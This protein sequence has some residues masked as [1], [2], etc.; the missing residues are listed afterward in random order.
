[1]DLDSSDTVF[2]F[3]FENSG[4]ILGI[5][6]REANII[7]IN[8]KWSN[9]LGYRK[10]EINGLNYYK[11]VHSD[12]V[13]DTEKAIELIVKKNKSNNITNRFKLKEGTYFLINW[14]IIPH[15]RYFILSGHII[16]SQNQE[17][18][19]LKKFKYSTDNAMDGVVWI[20]RQAGFDYVNR[21]VCESLGYTKEELLKLTVFDI[22]PIFKREDFDREWEDYLNNREERSFHLET[23]HKRKDGSVFPVEISSKHYWLGVTELHVAHIRDITKR[24]ENELFLNNFKASIES[25]VD[26]VYWINQEGRFEYFNTGACKMLGY[27]QEELQKLS[28]ADLDPKF[29]IEEH[30]STLE[31]MFKTKQHTSKTFERFHKKK[32]GTLFPVEVSTS[33][34]WF[35]DHGFLLAYVKD[36]TQRKLNDELLLRNQKLLNESQRIANMGSWELTLDDQS[37]YWSDSA[38]KVFGVNKEEKEIAHDT[39]LK[40]AHPDDIDNINRQI[41]KIIESGEITEDEFRIVK[42]NGEI[43]Y[44]TTTLDLISDENKKPIKIFGVVQ[45][46]T[47]KKISEEQLLM[48][49]Q[50]AEESEQR[51]KALHDASFGG[52]GIHDKG[53]ILDC[54]HGLSNITGFAYDELIGMDGLLLIAKKSRDIVMNNILSGYEKPYE[55]YGVKKNGEEY[56][57]RIQAKNIPYKGKQVRV[58]E[59]RDI[60]QKRNVETELIKAKEKAEESDRLKSAFLA[61]MSHE[62]RTPMNAII[63]FASF[64]KDED[65]TKQELDKYADIIINSGEHLLALINDIIDI[66]KIDA[67]QLDV[68]KSV[69]DINNL[70]KDLYQFFHSYLI[71][72]DRYDVHLKLNLPEKNIIAYTDETRLKQILIN[73]LGNAIKFTD[74][75][76]VDFGYELKNK[77]LQFYV[78]DTGIG[79][80]D[81]KKE[82]IFERFHQAGDTTERIYG[83]TGLGLAIAKACCDM[84]DGDIWFESKENKGTSFFFTIRYEKGETKATRRVRQRSRSTEFKKETILIAED[85]DY[86]YEYLKVILESENLKTIRTKTGRETIHTALENNINLI[87]MD[88]QLPDLTGLDATV[89]IKKAKPQIPIIAQTAYAMV[90]DKASCLSAGCSDYMSK[91]I[92]RE[93][94]LKKIRKY[95]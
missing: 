12:D 75:G 65:K 62:I 3:C 72:K 38:Y 10:E 74:H 19:F 77:H 85:D 4:E 47:E 71:S 81:H 66:S 95:L 51:Y 13:I 86:N 57:L 52:I 89:E 41:E 73:L 44:F 48:E 79:I 33:F 6:D 90:E 59:F 27:E 61:N 23:F 82:L 64:L 49:K 76:E 14:R 83:G 17:K 87:L 42:S 37:V 8:Q 94:L 54:N 50:R 78:K 84:L 68:I 36:I 55:V 91:P 2:E 25:T 24:K 56:P 34:I 9:C 67:G 22:D 7:R 43:R 5:I 30:L 45:D 69:V 1:M 39:F 92:D 28:L 53:K 26:A 15:E 40:I 88:I 11:L 35:D 58:V 46:I 70:M 32:D 93:L 21:R 63:G 31:K 80:S 16:T 60:T 18:D 29:T 20:N